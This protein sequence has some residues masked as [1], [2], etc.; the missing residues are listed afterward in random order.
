MSKYNC[1]YQCSPSNNNSPLCYNN[2][3][4]Q[5]NCPGCSAIKTNRYQENSPIQSNTYRQNQF[6]STLYQLHPYSYYNS[7]NIINSKKASLIFSPRVLNK[8]SK[9]KNTFFRNRTNLTNSIKYN[10]TKN[11]NNKCYNSPLQENDLIFKNLGRKYLNNGKTVYFNS[12]NKLFKFYRSN[13]YSAKNRKL[14]YLYSEN[15]RLKNLLKKVPKHEKNYFS[16]NI[17]PSVF[18]NFINKNKKK[19][20]SL[21]NTLKDYKN[22]FNNFSLSENRQVPNYKN[23]KS[24]VMP[25]NNFSLIKALEKINF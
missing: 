3:Q 13:S 6:S 4:F 2:C 23:Y 17:S 18:D 5:C 8:S 22:N 20:K 9:F 12:A 15:S 14:N 10:T 1:Q 25:V 19:S 11:N 7:P 24:F 16:N 21:T